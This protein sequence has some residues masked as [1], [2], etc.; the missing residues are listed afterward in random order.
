MEMPNKYMKK[1]FNT[2]RMQWKNKWKRGLWCESSF[3]ICSSSQHIFQNISTLYHFFFWSTFFS[4]R[5]C[6]IKLRLKCSKK[7]EDNSQKE[8]IAKGDK[9]AIK[10]LLSEFSS[11][12]FDLC[13]TFRG[14]TLAIK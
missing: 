2:M 11:S 1:V 8:M 5:I 7:L 3:F 10:K 13:Y 9:M 14:I 4:E 12:V 6:V